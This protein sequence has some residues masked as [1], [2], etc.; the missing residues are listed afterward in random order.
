MRVVV[1]VVVGVGRVGY[2]VLG[3]E[4]PGRSATVVLSGMK[5]STDDSGRLRRGLKGRP[6]GGGRRRRRRWRIPGLR[7][8]PVSGPAD[9]REPPAEPAA[10][11]SPG[12]FLA[13]A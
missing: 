5:V 13:S 1:V 3:K 2:E 9:L 7:S 6:P 8:G 4:K 11:P 10:F 12:F